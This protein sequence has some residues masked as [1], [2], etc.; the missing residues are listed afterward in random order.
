MTLQIHK[1][2]ASQTGLDFVCGDRKVLLANDLL[3]RSNRKS[4]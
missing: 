1:F 2:E 4:K 3:E